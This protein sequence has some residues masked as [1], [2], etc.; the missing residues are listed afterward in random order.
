MGS[1]LLGLQVT[2]AFANDPS[3]GEWTFEDSRQVASDL[4]LV[5]AAILAIVIVR[6]I[7]HFQIQAEASSP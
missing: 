3:Y 1:A 2:T 5:A 6:R 7:T 4:V